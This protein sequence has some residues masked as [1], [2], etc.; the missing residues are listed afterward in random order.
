MDQDFIKTASTEGIK[1]DRE[2]KYLIRNRETVDLILS[3]LPKELDFQLR[4]NGKID[5]AKFDSKGSPEIDS[6][7]EE[8][9]QEIFVEPGKEAIE[10][11][12]PAYKHE[13]NQYILIKERENFYFDTDSNDLLDNSYT[14]GLRKRDKDWMAVIKLR[15]QSQVKKGIQKGIFERIEVNCTID[16][17]IVEEAR[18][19][20]KININSII[21]KDTTLKET[22]EKQLKKFVAEKE[23][24][25][26]V[27]FL[28]KTH[29][30]LFP[31]PNGLVQ[32]SV[33]IIKTEDDKELYELEIK[34]KFGPQNSWLDSVLIRVFDYIC[35]S[36]IEN[37]KS[38]LSEKIEEVA[39]KQILNEV[40]H[41]SKI[42][43]VKNITS[44]K[45]FY[46]SLENE[47]Q[48]LYAFT[49]ALFNAFQ[50]EMIT[51][52]MPV[53]LCPY[54]ISISKVYDHI[55]PDP[56]EDPNLTTEKE[57][58]YK[59]YSA[60]EI[61]NYKEY[62]L[63][64]FIKHFD[65]V[66]SSST[67]KTNQ[68]IPP[69]LFSKTFLF[70]LSEQSLIAIVVLPFDE[71][72]HIKIYAKTNEIISN[73]FKQTAVSIQDTEIYEKIEID[74]SFLLD[75]LSISKTT[76]IQVGNMKLISLMD[77]NNFVEFE[78]KIINYIQEAEKNL[79][80]LINNRRILKNRNELEPAIIYTA[81][82][83]I[84]KSSVYSVISKSQKPM[85]FLESFSLD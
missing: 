46:E 30:V 66:V 78:E 67:K 29:R 18:D 7:M 6:V 17:E 2:R 25:P 14:L 15:P 57:V 53:L 55:K 44:P 31:V 60:L 23:L 77:D 38:K 49:T 80:R 74:I 63:S 51:D 27:A 69:H 83:R 40:T 84:N 1:I 33:D 8:C 59:K 61:E 79:Q 36:I 42:D 50:K 72:E 22:F 3:A 64:N 10:V 70:R 24:I 4:K 12:I 68:I 56:S 26:T 20:G 82:D 11:I 65:E 71:Y 62:F 28:V 13:N 5:S 32:I 85:L 81:G 76:Q 19:K 21:S 34:L 52:I 43:K 54:V 16:N 41:L 48:N 39:L 37:I 75:E 45:L 47:H 73:I 58:K 35:K 9:L